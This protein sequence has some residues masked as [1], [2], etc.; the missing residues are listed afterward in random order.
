MCC[1]IGA[2]IVCAHS[3][4]SGGVHASAWSMP[5]VGVVVGGLLAVGVAK[6]RMGCRQAIGLL[7]LA[8]MPQAC[9]QPIVTFATPTASNPPTTTPT[10]GMD[11]AIACTPPLLLE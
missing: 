7:Y 2:C 4:S 3:S 6:V 8:K 1:Q 10:R 11:H 9:L 5:R